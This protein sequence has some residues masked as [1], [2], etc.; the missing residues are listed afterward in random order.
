MFPVAEIRIRG[1][2][3]FHPK[4]DQGGSG[5]SDGKPADV[6]KTVTA[7]FPDIPE[8]RLEIVAKHGNFFSF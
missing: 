6:Q 2:F 3:I 8:K 7:G 1:Q 5:D 4:E